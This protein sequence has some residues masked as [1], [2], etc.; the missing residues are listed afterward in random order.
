[1]WREWAKLEIADD[2]NPYKLPKCRQ[3]YAGIAL[4]LAKEEKPDTS[5][6]TDAE[7]VRRISKP[8]HVGLIF[9]SPKHERIAEL[10]GIYTERI[11]NDFLAIAPKRER[12]DD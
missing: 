6:Y 2:E 10:L 7:I 8:K 9:C 12:Y 5:H 1:M 4:A 11:T 3:E